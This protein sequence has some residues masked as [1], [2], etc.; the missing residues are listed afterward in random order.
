MSSEVLCDHMSHER[1]QESDEG[2]GIELHLQGVVL[3]DAGRH[4]AEHQVSG[5]ENIGRRVRALDCGGRS[6]RTSME[7]DPLFQGF[8]AWPEGTRCPSL[9]PGRGEA[10]VAISRAQDCRLPPHR[11]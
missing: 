3:L 6:H 1:E 5:V 8:E 2:Q 9:A 4:G 10:D 11:S 7:D